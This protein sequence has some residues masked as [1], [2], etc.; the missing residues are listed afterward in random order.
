MEYGLI[1]MPLGHS[2]S[3]GIHEK[4]GGYAYS[5]HPLPPEELDA[6]FKARAFKGIN[7]TI[8][9]KRAVLPYC[10][11][12]D[13][14]A[15]A[16]GAVNTI[17]NR[18]G[19]LYGYN[20]D[21]MGF[22]YLA[23]TMGLTFRK[24]TV[25]I[26]GSGGTHDTAAAVAREQGAGQ[27]LTASRQSGPDRISYEDAARRKDVELVV[28][29]TPLGMYPNVDAQP[30][31]LS[32]FP[33]LQGVLDAVYNP[34]E[35]KLIQQS[36]ALGVPA[37]GGLAMLV[38]QAKYAA[39][40]FLNHSLPESAI[41]SITREIWRSR[42]NLVFIGMPGSGKTSVGRICAKALGRP[43]VDLDAYIAQEAGMSI[44]AIF[45]AEGEGGF[46][47]RESRAIGRVARET[48]QVIATGG[49]A[50][51]KEENVLALRQNGVLLHLL[52]PLEALAYGKGRPL[53][54]D[55]E[56][57]ARLWQE[58]MPLYQ[59][60]ASAQVFNTGT[61]TQTAQA[62]IECFNQIALPPSRGRAAERKG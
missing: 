40:L 6:F 54:Q 27:V 39:E 46:R 22:L 18:G 26:L 3:K 42:A 28:N 57:V 48:G 61:P 51:L 19:R 21:C 43:F 8:P 33:R 37:A 45:Q 13:P 60:A 17:V 56:A 7:V 50:I 25:L 53:S 52:R 44:P 49:G 2:F 62:A 55:K 15:K 12:L 38:A 47:A 32:G 4:L 31:D 36:R 5:L 34:L 1:G 23:R 16:I 10:Q 29:T 35:T 58:R 20:T 11:Y 9:Y 14:A 59:Q 41:G 24:R 30:L